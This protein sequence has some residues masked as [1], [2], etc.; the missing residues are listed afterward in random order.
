M[1]VPIH[2]SLGALELY[3]LGQGTKY[4]R[5]FPIDNDPG[6]KYPYIVVSAVDSSGK[7]VQGVQFESFEMSVLLSKKSVYDVDVTDEN[8]KAVLFTGNVIGGRERQVS[9][10]P[11]MAP[12]GYGQ[13]VLSDGPLGKNS[14]YVRVNGYDTLT[15]TGVF[16]PEV[17]LS[18]RKKLKNTNPVLQYVVPRST[19][20]V[21]PPRPASPPGGIMFRLLRP[22]GKTPVPA[23][24]TYKSIVQHHDGGT[25]ES[26]VETNAEGIFNI[27]QAGSYDMTYISLYPVF[28]IALATGT[29]LE[30]YPD[31]GIKNKIVKFGMSTPI[32]DIV[33]RKPD[34]GIL[35]GIPTYEVPPGSIVPTD[36]LKNMVNPTPPSATPSTT[37]PPTT[38]PPTPPSGDN[39][40]AKP[41]SEIPPDVTKK[42]EKGIPSYV[43]G[44][45]AAV[46]LGGAVYFFMSKNEEP[47]PRARKR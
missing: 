19:S 33:Y 22:D 31:E 40:P 37:T 4:E 14:G 36:Y 45:G 9:V 11:T 34:G 16:E 29:K 17:S 35:P 32:Y 27:G 26:I 44:I 46:L 2:M 18:E 28:K 24:V 43:W 21:L 23:G 39:P 15:T 13:P 47:A 42:D 30:E 5:T 20:T 6:A 10:R 38:T 12:A 41:K 8:G 1:R 7:P 3:G 25:S